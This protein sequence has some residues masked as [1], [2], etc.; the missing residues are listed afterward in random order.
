MRA[1]V[2]AAAALFL[3]G[4]VSDTTVGGSEGRQSEPTVGS[5]PTSEPTAESVPTSEPTADDEE[6]DIE[7]REAETVEPGPAPCEDVMFQRAQGTIRSQQSAFANDDFD[8]ARAFA[9]QSFQKSVSVEQFRSIIQ[10]TYGFLLD[11]PSIAFDDCQRDGDAALIRLEISGS[12]SV[13][14]V[15]R[16]VLENDTWFIDAA[17]IAGTREDVSA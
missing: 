5:V 2:L 1:L 13:L 4:C 6:A 8:A 11:D 16:V 17:S 15:Y 14:M 10:G 7:P 12:P 9:S 3:A